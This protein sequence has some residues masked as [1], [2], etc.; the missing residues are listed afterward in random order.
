VIAQTSGST[1]SG[2]T[3]KLSAGPTFTEEQNGG[4]LLIQ[5]QQN[6]APGPVSVGASS[7]GTNAGR[8]YLLAVGVKHS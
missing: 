6:A 8:W 4:I 3:G 7:A 5:D 2:F 1:F